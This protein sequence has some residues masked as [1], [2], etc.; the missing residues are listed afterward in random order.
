MYIKLDARWK[1][2]IKQDREIIEFVLVSLQPEASKE[3][4]QNI[5]LNSKPFF[6]SNKRLTR[7]LVGESQSIQDETEEILKNFSGLIPKE[8][9]SDRLKGDNLPDNVNIDEIIPDKISFDNTTVNKHIEQETITIT[10]E[11]TMLPKDIST[12]K[13]KDKDV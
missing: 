6:R 8:E 7:L 1:A 3:E 2:A 11:E 4:L 5:L 10:D 9:E 13:N 12:G